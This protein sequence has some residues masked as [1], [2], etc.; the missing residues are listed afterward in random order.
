LDVEIRKLRDLTDKLEEFK[1]KN[2]IVS[3]NKKM[4]TIEHE[5]HCLNDNPDY[6]DNGEICQCPEV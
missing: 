1:V 4:Y 2:E 6:A 5:E 3:R